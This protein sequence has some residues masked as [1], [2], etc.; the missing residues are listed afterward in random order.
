MSEVAIK[1]VVIKPTS[2]K[3]F[4]DIVAL[5]V[6]TSLVAFGMLFLKETGMVMGGTAGLSLLL[7][8]KL[9]IPFG[10]LFFFINLPFYYL[11][12]RQMGWVFTLK[13]FVAVGLVSFISNHQSAVV[14][15]E[16]LNPIYAAIFGGFLFAVGLI[17]IFRHKASLGG[18]S[19]LALFMQ[20][21]FGVRVGWTLMVLD[22]TIMIIS[23]SVVTPIHLVLSILCAVT[24]NVIIALNHRTDRYHV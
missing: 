8:Y 2:H 13:T 23:V 15:I 21:K 18:F 9:N 16:H 1:P 10:T 24:L 20:K 19:I 5:F 12:I 22:M 7:H 4:E 14:Q 17:I 6:G 11:A 3:W